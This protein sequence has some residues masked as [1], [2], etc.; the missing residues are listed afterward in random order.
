MIVIGPRD[1]FSEKIAEKLGSDFIELNP[2]VFSDKEIKP[3]ITKEG[4]SGEDVLFVDRMKG[5]ELFNPNQY[6]VEFLFSLK[7]IKESGAKS[8]TALMPYFVYSRQDKVFLPGEPFSA[9]YV[10]ELI[11][12]AGADKFLTISSH[13]KR[14]TGKI[15]LVPDLDAFNLSA[16]PTIGN[17]FKST[18]GSDLVV[19]SPDFGSSR[20]VKEV[21]EVLGVQEY[22]LEKD[23]DLKTGK[24]ETSGKVDVSGKNVLIVDDI[25]ASGGTLEK[26]INVCKEN[27]AEKIICTVV[28]PV[29][30]KNCLEKVKNTGSE[31]LATTTIDSEIS[32]IDVTS[33][34]ADFF[35]TS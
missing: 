13:I 3:T 11:R 24:I 21:A 18:S 28:H 17:H 34:V 32:K 10:L 25:A 29:L 30:A 22:S 35:K 2:I 6:L 4:F 1:G 27:N 12:D 15:E 23:R 5:A 7:N 26:A 14:E 33:L 19:I 8:I 20:S 16:F 9:K 31:F